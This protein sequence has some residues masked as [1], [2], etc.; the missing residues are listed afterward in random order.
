MVQL[1]RVFF[2]LYLRVLAGED[3]IDRDIADPGDFKEKIRWR[4]APP[5]I[6]ADVVLFLDSECFCELDLIHSESLSD[7]ANTD[8][9][10]PWSGCSFHLTP[11]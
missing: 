4:D 8:S 11:S 3:P 1:G 5:L 10:F 9:N 6:P 2:L 7:L